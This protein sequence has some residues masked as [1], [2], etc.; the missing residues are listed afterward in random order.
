M[1]AGNVDLVIDQGEDWTVQLYWTDFFDDPH[2]LTHPLRMTIKSPLGQN[3]ISLNSV[4]PE[5]Q[6][7]GEVQSVSWSED[8]G[9]IQIHIPAAQTGAFTP[10]DYLY[11]LFVT[12]NADPAVEF[13][14]PLNQTVRLIAGRVHVNKRITSMA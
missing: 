13:G 7:P 1:A 2:N 14:S 10:G 6:V 9:W 8:T 3:L 4:L 5:D 11:D 12:L